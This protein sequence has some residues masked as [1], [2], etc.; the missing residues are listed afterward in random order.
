M[1]VS[2][3]FVERRISPTRLEI[4]RNVKK[5]ALLYGIYKR[6]S[7]GC[8]LIAKQPERARSGPARECDSRLAMRKIS[9]SQ[10]VAG[11]CWRR[12]KKLGIAV[13]W[14]LSECMDICRLTLAKLFE[15]VPNSLCVH[16]REE[17][18]SRTKAE[19]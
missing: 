17:K 1:C 9:N 13:E 16:E 6:A 11:R 14:I 19:Y 18:I 8:I 4:R 5:L 7:V 3:R 12:S 2:E 10:R 15:D